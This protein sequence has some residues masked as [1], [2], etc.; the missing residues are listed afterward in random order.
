MRSAI[1]AVL[2]SVA[3]TVSVAGASHAQGSASTPSSAG[4]GISATA[5]S[6]GSTI[7]L[8]NG[9]AVRLPKNFDS[10]S[11]AELAKI[12]VTPGMHQPGHKAPVD[13][14]VPSSGG[15]TPDNAYKCAGYVCL[16]VTS[17]N[18]HG[19]TVSSWGTSADN[20]GPSNVRFCTYSAYWGGTTG[21]TLIDTG[22]EVCGYPPGTFYGALT[23]SV[24]WS[25]SGKACN[26]WISVS[27]RPCANITP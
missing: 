15:V 18:G 22:T 23:Y 11:I 20:T 19:L 10:M 5:G 1:T 16:Q 24:H 3:L 17:P 14:Y 9:K 21:G 8:P 7:T 12:G 26:S 4:G 27:G 25:S 13:S 6:A 2:A